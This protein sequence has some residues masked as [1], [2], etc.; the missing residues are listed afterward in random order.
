MLHID[1]TVA[2]GRQFF[3]NDPKLQR[4]KIN[5]LNIKEL[6]KRN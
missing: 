5:Q 3:N 6:S 4:F 1:L 2:I